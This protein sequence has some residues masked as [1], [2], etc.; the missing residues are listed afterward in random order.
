MNKINIRDVAEEH[1]VSPKGRFELRRR[2]ISLALGGKKDIGPWGGGHPFDIELACLPPGKSNFPLHSHAAQTEHYAI[3]SGSGVMVDEKGGSMKLEA[4]DHVICHP[5]EAHQITN[6]GAEE[7]CYYV[8]TDHHRAEVGTYPRTG[9]RY[10]KP[11]YRTVT[12]VNIDYY[13]GEE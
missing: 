11:E 5:E 8:I 1:R 12:A 10:I 13:E 9:K 2:H 3:L 7:L 4:G 6:D